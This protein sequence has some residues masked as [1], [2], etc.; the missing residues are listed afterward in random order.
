MF[1]PVTKAVLSAVLVAIP[2]EL[3]L[4]VSTNIVGLMVSMD[5]ERN[6][7]ANNKK[8][9]VLTPKK[10]RTYKKGNKRRWFPV[11]SLKVVSWKYKI[12]A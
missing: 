8:A 10:R 3:L 12:V 9:M 4:S 5:K 2:T 11:T 7:G 1:K 6:N